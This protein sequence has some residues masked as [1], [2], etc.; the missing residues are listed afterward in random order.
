MDLNARIGQSQLHYASE[1][2]RMSPFEHLDNTD[3][4]GSQQT[5]DPVHPESEQSYDTPRR[6]SIV[7]HSYPQSFPYRPTTIIDD[8][9][10]ELTLEYEIQQDLGDRL[11]LLE[12]YEIIILCDD[13]GSMKTTVDNTNRTRWDELRDIIKIVLKIGTIFDTTGVDVY[14]LN[15]PTI[16]NVTDP[17]SINIEFSQ[18]PRGYTPLVNALRHIFNLPSTRR[19]NDKKVLVFVATDGAPSDDRGNINVNELEHLMIHERRIETTHV[20]FLIC[21]DDSTCVEYL[22]DWDR[23]MTNVDVTDDFITERKKIRQV[24]GE[25]Y[26]FSKGD[27]IVKA[28]LGAIDDDMDKLNEPPQ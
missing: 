4:A 9:L 13:S 24:N 22:N 11:R 15:R 8:R 26:P 16:Y 18:Q 20:M 12:D 14:F 27:Y 10:R 1:S 7:F 2:G 3:F 21:T 23:K 19:G 28:L 25:N 6:S 5:K 17:E